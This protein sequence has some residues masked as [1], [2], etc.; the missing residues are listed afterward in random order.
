MSFDDLSSTEKTQIITDC[1]RLIESDLRYEIFSKYPEYGKEILEQI[2]GLQW[3]RGRSF[4]LAKEGEGNWFETNQTHKRWLRYKEYLHAKGDNSEEDWEEITR[5]IDETTTRALNYLENPSTNLF[6]S[7]V[8]GLVVGYVQ[9]GKTANFTGLLAKAADAGYNVIIIM[10]GITNILRNQTQKRLIQDL[11]INQLIQRH[12]TDDYVITNDQSWIPLTQEDTEHRTPSRDISISNDFGGTPYAQASLPYG[13]DF[14]RLLKQGR[15]MLAV[16]K[17][18]HERLGHLSDW[19]LQCPETLKSELKVLMID[20]EA[21]SA[22]INNQRPSQMRS[23]EEEM[24]EI[25]VERDVIEVDDDEAT[26][27]NTHI[28]TILHNLPNTAYLGYT[29][30]PYASLLSDPGDYSEEI[31]WSLYPRNFVL[32]LPKPDN[33]DGTFEFFDR[34]GSLSRQVTS[35]SEAEAD[36]SRDPPALSE[37]TDRKLPVQLKW[38]VADFF[39][40][41]AIK[42]MRGHTDFHHS[43]L[44]HTSINVT[45]HGRLKK[46]VR[47]LCTFWSHEY[48]IN[49]WGKRSDVYQQFKTRWETEF[50]IQPEAE[51][52]MD[53]AMKTFL[54]NFDPLTMIRKINSVPPGS[55]ELIQTKNKLDYNDVPGG[56]KVIAIGGAILSRGLTVEGLTISYFTRETAIGDSLTQMARWCGFHK[57][58]G[59]LIRVRTTETIREWFEWIH[60]VETSLR[61]DIERYDGNPELS[62]LV[63]APRVLKHQKTSPDMRTIEPTR[64]SAMWTAEQYSRGLNGTYPE[65]NRFHLNDRRKLEENFDLMK[66]M[67]RDIQESTQ[68][69]QIEKMAPGSLLWTNVPVDLIHTFLRSYNSPPD[70]TRFQYDTEIRPYIERRG[71]ELREWSVVLINNSNPRHKAE[72]ILTEIGIEES[73]G[74]NERGRRVGGNIEQLIDKYHTAIGLEGFPEN[75]RQTEGNPRDIAM[76][77]RPFNQPLLLIYILD[78]NTPARDGRAPHALFDDSVPE[79]DRE[80]VISLGIALPDSPSIT[81]DE[82]RDYYHAR[83]IRPE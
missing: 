37:S 28:R 25:E 38:A 72:P 8:K 22:S 9:S 29:A 49:I 41:G 58:W 19:L 55:D 53:T 83:G 67:I 62:P 64:R 27:I 68:F 1:Q 16:V 42:Q 81:Q 54:N 14:G 2:E 74:L 18:R 24:D 69:R 80:H 66:T 75:F 59:D 73:I 65:T 3:A 43:M 50:S 23:S 48:V 57:D 31:G 40:T 12:S 70:E 79:S 5:I 47:N 17:K 4:A 30:T 46:K 56:L 82:T 60:D 78:K 15:P 32:T 36:T 45:P 44:I 63:L 21:D 26:I 6:Q 34:E 33:H 76:K 11:S 10:A 39:I 13:G 7:K 20:D 61:G 51:D 52:E 35:V 71:D 77:A